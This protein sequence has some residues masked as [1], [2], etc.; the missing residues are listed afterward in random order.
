MAASLTTRVGRPNAFEKSKPTQPGP[1]LGGSRAIDP[2][3]THPGYPRETT[4][5]AASRTSAFT[6]FTISEGVIFGPETMRTSGRPARY[7]F[8]W[9]PPTSRTRTLGDRRG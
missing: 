2:W 5:Y 1:R 6:C 4:S 7:A 3:S 8:T 9:E